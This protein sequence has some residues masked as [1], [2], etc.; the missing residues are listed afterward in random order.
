MDK[1]IIEALRV[2]TFIGVN[3]W[4]QSVKQTLVISIELGCDIR[5]AAA[6]DQLTDAVDY[7][8]IANRIIAFTSSHH[9]QLLEVVAEQL[10][11]LLLDNFS[12]HY[13][14]IDVRKT[15]AIAQAAAAG[16][17]IERSREK[18]CA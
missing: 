13:V 1:V 18:S 14:K 8:S 9:F 12:I 6:T 2:D 7:A 3:A 5:K 11:Q 4:E 15:D 17:Q 10:T 16:V